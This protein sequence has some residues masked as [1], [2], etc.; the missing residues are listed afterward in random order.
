VNNGQKS[1]NATVRANGGNN[2]F[3]DTL[4]LQHHNNPSNGNGTAAPNGNGATEEIKEMSL[5]SPISKRRASKLDSF[6]N[7]LDP[8]I[9][10]NKK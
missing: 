1:G 9:P 3:G 10:D 2:N 8:I 5:L 6:N 4:Q 7:A